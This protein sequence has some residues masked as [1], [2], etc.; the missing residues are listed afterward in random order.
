MLKQIQICCIMYVD[1]LHG[2]ECS[3]IKPRQ[4]RQTF[5]VIIDTKSRNILLNC[6]NLNTSNWTM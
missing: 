4:E 5:S 2:Y 3:I 6:P 1:R